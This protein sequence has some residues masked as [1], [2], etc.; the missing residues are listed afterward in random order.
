MMNISRMIVDI[1]EYEHSKK[2]MHKLGKWHKWQMD[3]GYS[4]LTEDVIV[5]WDT[6]Y[7]V[8]YIIQKDDQKQVNGGWQ[9]LVIKPTLVL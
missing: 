8:Q 5:N 2:S 9:E 6:Q 4:L 3:R 7:V 1:G